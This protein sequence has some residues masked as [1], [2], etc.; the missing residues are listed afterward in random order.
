MSPNTATRRPLQGNSCN[1][2]NTCVTLDTIASYQFPDPEALARYAHYPAI[3][4]NNRGE[5]F[6]LADLGFSLFER[7]W[8]LR[9]M[10]NL[11]ADFHLNPGFVDD[12]LDAIDEYAAECETE[13]AA[14]PQP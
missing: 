2:C 10:E 4:A 5:R 13:P 1:T 7:A 14:L 9:G 8:T 11:L 3:L 12:L 6:V